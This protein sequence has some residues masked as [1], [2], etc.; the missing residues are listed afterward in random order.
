M[1]INTGVRQNTHILIIQQNI[2]SSDRDVVCSSKSEYTI[3]YY[4]GMHFCNYNFT[5]V[6]WITSACTMLVMFVSWHSPRYVCALVQPLP[7]WLLQQGSMYSQ[8]GLD[9]LPSI[10]SIV[11]VLTLVH[12][13]SSERLEMESFRTPFPCAMLLWPLR[14]PSHLLIYQSLWFVHLWNW[15]FHIGLVRCGGSPAELPLTASITALSAL[16]LW[17]SGRP[18]DLSASQA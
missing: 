4:K 9:P 2:I 3:S 7:A 17:G 6:F 13:H 15:S 11:S 18:A 16:C 8:L 10:P 14:R 12:L 5:L 1:K